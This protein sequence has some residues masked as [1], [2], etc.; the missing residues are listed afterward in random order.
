M[1]VEDVWCFGDIVGGNKRQ[2]EDEEPHL[3]S[4]N[5]GLYPSRLHFMGTKPK[6]FQTSFR[7]SNSAIC[8][9]PAKIQ[10]LPGKKWLWCLCL[11]PRQSSLSVALL[12]MLTMLT[13]P[14]LLREGS[15]KLSLFYLL[16]DS[17]MNGGI[18]RKFY[19]ND[20]TPNCPVMVFKEDTGMTWLKSS[21]KSDLKIWPGCDSVGIPGCAVGSV[22]GFNLFGKHI[23]VMIFFCK[24]IL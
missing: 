6:H 17:L 22:K 7:H 24:S 12:T 5:W 10:A 14:T 4:W 16:I 2:Q 11:F 19:A 15:K 18:L 1:D 8:T 9:Q 20:T 13:M 3:Q 21:G 23:Y